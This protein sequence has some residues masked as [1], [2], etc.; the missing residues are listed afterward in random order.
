MTKKETI[1]KISELLY[2]NFVINNRAAAIQQEDGRYITMYIPV[3]IALIEQMIKSNGSMGCY[4]QGYRSQYIKWICIDFDCKNKSNPNLTVLENTLVSKL[5]EVLDSKNIHYL[6]EFSGRRGIHIW[7][8]FDST[9][10]KSDGYGIISSLLRIANL[11]HIEGTE[12]GID[13][14]PQT[15]SSSGNIVGKQVKIPLS[16]HKSGGRSYFFI[17]SYQEIDDFFSADFFERQLKI[18]ENYKPNKLS[19]V[20]ESLGIEEKYQ[21]YYTKIYKPALVYKDININFDEVVTILSEISIYKNI[22]LRMKKGIPNQLDWFVLL[23]TFSPLDDNSNFLS[24]FLSQYPLFDEAITNENIRRLKGKY[25]PPTFGYLS[26]IYNTEL[27]RE[28]DPESTGLEYLLKRKGIPFK[29]KVI[30]KP[31]NKY[32]SKA[33]I[34]DTIKKE[35]NYLLSN[36]EAPDITILNKLKSFKAYDATIISKTIQKTLEDTVVPTIKDY[37]IL[38][39]HEGSN[40]IRKMVSLSAFDRVLTTQLALEI[41]K[42]YKR[43][44]SNCLFSFSYNPSL[45]SRTEIFYSWYTSWDNYISSLKSLLNVSFFSEYGIFYI[46]LKDFYGSI[47]FITVYELLHTDLSDV[48]TKKIKYLL[49]FNDKIM[50][51]INDGIRIGVPQ[52]PAYAR[53]IAEIFLNRVISIFLEKYNGNIRLYKYVDDMVF[54]CEPEI[55]VKET[56][57][58]AIKHLKS[59][60]LNVN[61][62][63]SKC[64]HTIGTLTEDEKRYL[65]HIDRF[66]YDLRN[67]VDGYTLPFFETKRKV[68]FYIFKHGFDIWKLGYY[69]GSQTTETAKIEIF[70]KYREEILSSIDGRGSNFRRFYEFVLQKDELVSIISEEHL[71][72]AIPLNSVNF[73]NYV[74]SIYLLNESGKLLP[75]IFNTICREHLSKIN[76]DKSISIEDKAV[77]DALLLLRGNNK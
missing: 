40:K 69:F 43:P 21:T 61:L 63:K 39:R 36:D 17:D 38:I 60:G 70:N 26:N 27:E 50:S 66:N 53:I 34:E 2:N 7:I 9:I 5:T 14:F 4:Q 65:L 19:D 30:N 10:T 28:L 73:S 16:C 51:L 6:K 64:Y 42:E 62:E 37:R 57:Y 32:S 44:S 20:K 31:N 77:I 72:D 41:V 23:G 45:I 3:S 8:L 13:R 55:D 71:F 56:Y 47:D 29:E 12:F 25:H 46:D 49:S 18:I 58:D 76:S 48:A 67:T 1:K 54:I 75:D 74:S 33:N 22:F 11:E 68:D 15:P 52:G 59:Y 24:F 35:I